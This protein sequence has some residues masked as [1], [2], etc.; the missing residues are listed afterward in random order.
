M[1]T[2]V[3]NKNN[4][5]LKTKIKTQNFSTYSIGKFDNRTIDPNTIIVFKYVKLTQK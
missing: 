4:F 2:K 5:S 1:N 3:L